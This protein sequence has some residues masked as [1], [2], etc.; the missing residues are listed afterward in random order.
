VGKSAFRLLTTMNH[1]GGKSNRLRLA[2]MV[3]KKTL[4]PPYE[5][6]EGLMDVWTGQTVK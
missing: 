6:Y 1:D 3:G 4:C 5:N 2:T